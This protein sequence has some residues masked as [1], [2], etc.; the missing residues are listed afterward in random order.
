M[1]AMQGPARSGR[2]TWRTVLPS[3]QAQTLQR[4][5]HTACSRQQALRPSSNKTWPFSLFEQ[6]H[7]HNI[8][9]CPNHFINFIITNYVQSE[10]M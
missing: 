10:D 1:Y 7:N 4:H 9:I 3:L 6:P 5:R 8:H 2:Q